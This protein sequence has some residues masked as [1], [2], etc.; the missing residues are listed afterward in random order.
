[1]GEAGRGPEAVCAGG[2]GP[3]SGAQAGGEQARVLPLKGG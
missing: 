1:M 3:R 2:Q